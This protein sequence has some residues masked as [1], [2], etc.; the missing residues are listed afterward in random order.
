M[1]VKE[2]LANERHWTQG[3]FARD[4]K[5]QEIGALFPEAACWCLRGAL[6]RCY[7]EVGPA[8][9][10]AEN[11]IKEVL[12]NNGIVRFNDDESTTH[13]DVLRVLEAADV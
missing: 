9:W 12:G 11:R 8:H 10:Q 7:G 5:G 4:A 2:L 3:T 13:A 6:M 1:K